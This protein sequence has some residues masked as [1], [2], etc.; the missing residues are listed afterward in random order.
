MRRVT[1][2]SACVA[3]LVKDAFLPFLTSVLTLIAMFVILWQLNAVLTLASM[4]VVPFLLLALWCHAGPMMKQSYVQQEAEGQ[5]YAVIERTLSAVPV[6]QAFARE[7]Q[8]N[9]QYHASTSASL[10]A[11]LAVIRTQLYFK[12]FVGLSTAG[13][14]ALIMWIGAEQVMADKLSI[15][16]VFVFLS[17]LAALYAP[18]EAT[19]YT[20]TTVQ[21]ASGSAR[22]VLEV[23]ESDPDVQERPDAGPLAR[24]RGDVRFEGVTFGYERGRGVLHGIDLEASPGQ[25]VA[26]VGA[27]GA[28]KSTLVSLIP[29]FFDPWE[30]A[31]TIDGKD[32]RDVRLRDLR[33]QV[34]VVLQEPFLFP[35]SVAENIA[36]GRPEATRAQIENAARAANAHD[37]T[38][39]L[40]SGYDTVIGERGG[41][42]SGGERQRLSI[43]RA[44]V[45]DAPILI[46]D[47]PTSAVDARTEHL[48][49]EALR[50]LM[51]GRTTFIIAHRLSTVRHADRI[52]VL[53]AGRIIETGTHEELI[54][55]GRTYAHL[56]H[57][58][59]SNVST[60]NV[61][62]QT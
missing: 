7:D 59:Q 36:Y 38:M 32:L 40:P 16:G 5:V 41:T 9:A 12:F 13:G 58:L 8:A 3:T 35:M 23:L 55:Q 39:N 62:E 50:R 52:I 20:S 26:I 61:T 47:E 27:T 19:V 57:L 45:K 29:R 33:Q 21:S 34:A 56:C 11:S 37:F 24:V 25:T 48:V 17:Y 10:Q 4:A 44:L 54:R 53:E 42:L 18:L 43:A 51:A 49:V 6:V 60:E 30:G 1:G 15:G 2:D 31:V 22:R 46:L 28:G 14:T